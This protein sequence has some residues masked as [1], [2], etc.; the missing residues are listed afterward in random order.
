[1]LGEIGLG[2][3][4]PRG[5]TTSMTARNATKKK[6]K[7][8]NSLATKNA[9]RKLGDFRARD[10]FFSFFNISIAKKI[11]VIVLLTKKVRSGFA[12]LGQI[13]HVTENTDCYGF[14]LFFVFFEY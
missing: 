7:G 14:R 4:A 1:M 12:S 8:K 13:S 9:P 11:V 10:N 2:I 6:S 5:L 3:P